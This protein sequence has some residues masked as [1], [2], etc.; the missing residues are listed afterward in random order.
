VEIKFSV[1]ILAHMQAR[2]ATTF[3]PRPINNIPRDM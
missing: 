3:Q 1:E 2:H